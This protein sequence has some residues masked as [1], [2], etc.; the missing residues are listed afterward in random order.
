MKLILNVQKAFGEDER[1]RIKMMKDAGF[2][3]FFCSWNVNADMH[4]YA[5][6]AK[7]LG[8][9]FQSI[10][11]PFGGICNV[12]GDDEEKAEAAV[13]EQ[14]ACVEDAGK[15]GVDLVICHTI[16]GMDAHTPTEIGLKRFGKIVAAAKSAGVR[17]A[18]ENTEGI[19]YLDALM[20]YFK[21]VENVGFCWDSGH[22]MCYNYSRDQLAKY[23]HRLFGTHLNDNLGIRNPDEEITW[24]DDLHLLPFDGIADWKHNRDR[25][26]KCGFTGPLTFELTTGS[27]PGRHENDIYA[28]MA[29]EV[30]L[31]ECYKRACRVRAL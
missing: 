23:G 12:W 7:E 17:I 9:I 6:A 25:L 1:S 4:K 5:D 29:P 2:D 3:G 21:D 14:I 31:A 20:E 19:E 18:F 8:M 24:L 30:Y 26:R 27:K 13:R 22:E 15:V 28:Q 11:A 10:H 16:I